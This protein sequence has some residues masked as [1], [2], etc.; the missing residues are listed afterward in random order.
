[1]EKTVREKVKAESITLRDEQGQWLGQ[2]VLTEDGMFASVTDWGNFSYAWRNWGEG[3][4]K[5][6]LCSINKHY[7][8]EKMKIGMSYGARM[9]KDICERYAEI[10]LPA[11]QKHLKE[12]SND[13]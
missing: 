12:D 4:F 1:M 7:F 8:A 6:F 3:S 13:K 5:D 2:I 9:N 10:I 11:L